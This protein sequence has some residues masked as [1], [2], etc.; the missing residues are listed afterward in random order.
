MRS[1]RLRKGWEYECPRLWEQLTP[2]DEPKQRFCQQC[3][4][5]VFYCESLEELEVHTSQRRCVA[6]EVKQPVAEGA[7]N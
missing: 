5:T 1:C 2:T 3:R 7:L 6:F 4:E